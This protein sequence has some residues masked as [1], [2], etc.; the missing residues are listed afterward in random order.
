MKK[1]IYLLI[2]TV[3]FYTAFLFTPWGLGIYHFIPLV[4]AFFAQLYCQVEYKKLKKKYKFDE[5]K[6]EKT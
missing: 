4:G 1:F 5:N 2:L 3:F 6:I